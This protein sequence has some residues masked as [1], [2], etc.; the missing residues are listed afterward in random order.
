MSKNVDF[1][2][3]TIVTD[4]FL[5]S[6]QELLTGTV[7]NLRLGPSS[8]G[9]DRVALFLAGD[10]NNDK[11]GTANVGGRYVYTDVTQDS[12]PET[13]MANGPKTIYLSTTK[14]GSPQ[15]PAFSI[16][17]GTSPPTV[18]SP[19]TAYTRELGTATRTGAQLHNV[20]M[21]NGT[22]A[23]A[24]QYNEFTFRSAIDFEG[25]TDAENALL[26]RL[27]GQD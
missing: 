13:T 15:Q 12:E 3:G 2:I 4:V 8:L 19:A 24:D 27:R 5:D 14:N 17:V 18:L 9:T 25:T 16:T 10:T 20:K 1:E 22:Q 26:L 7:N 21:H 23:D 6:V 11:R